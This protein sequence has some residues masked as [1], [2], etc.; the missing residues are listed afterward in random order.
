[1]R[2]LTVR[3][4]ANHYR[5]SRDT[6][7]RWIKKGRIAADNIGTPDLPRYRIRDCNLGALVVESTN[8]VPEDVIEFIS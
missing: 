2:Y 7:V 1:M 8:A 4:V 6:I 5:V 3:E